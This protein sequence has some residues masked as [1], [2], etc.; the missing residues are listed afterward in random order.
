L[1]H[2]HTHRPGVH[3]LLSDG[4]RTMRH[5]LADW[6]ETGSYLRLSDHAC[7]AVSLS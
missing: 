2:G 6:Y 4:K 3:E 7:E 1:I 5:V